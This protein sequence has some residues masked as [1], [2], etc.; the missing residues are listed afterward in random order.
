M[1]I[2]IVI[3]S[4]SLEHQKAG[5]SMHL[6]EITIF[7]NVDTKKDMNVELRTTQQL[8]TTRT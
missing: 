3:S 1:I 5:L 4:A 8:E 6:S 7:Q 2:P